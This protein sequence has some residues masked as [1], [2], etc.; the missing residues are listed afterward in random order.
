MLSGFAE[1]MNWCVY[2]IEC[3][4]RLLY[5]G[6]TSDVNRRLNEHNSNKGCRYTKGKTPVKL[7]FSEVYKTKSAAKRRESQ[8][9]GWTRLKKK[10]LIEKNHERLKKLSHS[11]K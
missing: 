5:T 1:N 9:K 6:I 3:S 7:V 2:I 10:A 8:L 11:N 4:D